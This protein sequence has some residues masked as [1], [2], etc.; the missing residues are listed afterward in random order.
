MFLFLSSLKHERILSIDR[1]QLAN[2]CMV[3]NLDVFEGNEYEFLIE[4]NRVMKAI[5]IAL[6]TLE[7]NKYAFGVYLPTLFGLRLKLAALEKQA[8]HCLELVLVIQ[9]VF[10]ERFRSVLDIFDGEGK[11]VP[12]FVAMVS[13]PNYKLSYMGLKSIPSHTLL[14]IKQMLFDSAMDILKNETHSDDQNNDIQ[15]TNQGNYHLSIIKPL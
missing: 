9:N 15:S 14:R 10:E 3:L 5:A 12:A 1:E 4:Y 13:N 6:K 11:S 2:V 7:A 8:V